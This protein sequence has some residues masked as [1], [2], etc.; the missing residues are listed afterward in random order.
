MVNPAENSQQGGSGD[1]TRNRIHAIH[2]TTSL[3]AIELLLGREN[4]STWKFAVQ[5][6]LE[7]ED[8][9]EVVKPTPNADGTDPV[10]DA[11]KD[12]RARAK[13]ILL[14][15]PVNYVHVREAK[16]AREAW[17]KLEAAFE[18]SGLTRKVGL[19]RKLITTSLTT[20]NSMETFVN[21]V[22]ATAH[23]LRGIGFEITDE[24]IGTLLLAG[25]PEEY[26]PMIM[27]L[28]NSGAAITGDVIKTKLLQEI[29]VPSSGAAFASNKHGRK[30]AKQSE[31]PN[32]SSRKGPKCRRCHKFG[33]IARDCSSRE[34]KKSD[35]NAWCTVMSA[36]EED[37]DDWYFD[38]GASNHFAKTAQ[39]LE[40]STKCGGTVVAANRGAMKIVA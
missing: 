33:H 15:D 21:D 11:V 16:S 24:W 1:A 5:T 22:I 38:S 36:I 26:R 3:P 37:D 30:P 39:A 17:S 34:P 14:L 2:G 28:E 19:L 4:W 27:A 9:W 25:L 31:K 8:L 35:G 40:E 6:F 20:S 23:Q 32:P 29:R 12:R 10:V 7:L 18:D 13:I